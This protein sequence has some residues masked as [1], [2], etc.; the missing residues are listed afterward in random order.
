MIL[1]FDWNGSLRPFQA[2]LSSD[3][4]TGRNLKQ[5]YD[6]M[7]MTKDGGTMQAVSP[8]SVYPVSPLAP[9]VRAIQHSRLPE[10]SSPSTSD[11]RIWLAPIILYYPQH[12]TVSIINFFDPFRS[13]SGNGLRCFGLP[14]FKSLGYSTIMQFSLNV[15]NQ[16]I[17][18]A[19]AF[20]GISLSDS[21]PRRK[22][23]VFGTIVVAFM[24]CTIGSISEL[25]VENANTGTVDPRGWS[26]CPIS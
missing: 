9:A 26:R 10:A 8:V 24:L 16:F 17:S 11:G 21:M 14:I 19:G 4:L 2:V 22:A 20:L 7:R 23:L 13:F 15:L 12:S 5:I 3:P 18:A 6:R 1:S 25:W